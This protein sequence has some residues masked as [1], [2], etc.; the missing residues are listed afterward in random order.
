[1]L[2]RMDHRADDASHA[3]AK[4]ALRRAMRDVWNRAD[5]PAAE[6]AV[7]D[8]LLSLPVLSAASTVAAYDA[9]PDEIPTRLLVDRLRERDI[10]VLLPVLHDG[11][12]L[13][14]REHGS[15]PL[16]DGLRGTRHPGGDAEDVALLTAAVV[17]VPGRAF[18]PQGRRLGRGGGSYDRALAG[19]RPDAVVVGLAVDGAVVDEVPTA[20]HDRPVDIVV[21]PTRV[22]LCRR[23]GC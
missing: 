12:S 22:V 1:M 18:D 3:D 4:A 14:W 10:R 23:P 7:V 19:L 20:A 11:G 8:R 16:A 21:T 2:A 9:L 13:T 17:I 6:R 5:L 15:A